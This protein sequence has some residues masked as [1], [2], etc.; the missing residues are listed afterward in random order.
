M[1]HLVFLWLLAM[2]ILANA[3]GVPAVTESVETIPSRGSYTQTFLFLRV[4]KP[5]ATL[6]L[7]S[8]NK[9]YV[10]IF[11]NGSAQFDMFFVY[12]A[13]RLLAQQGFNVLLLDAPSEWGSGGL[14]E[15]QRTPEYIAHNSA[16]LAWARKQT[17]VPV[18]LV[19]QSSGGITAAA[20]ASQLKGKGADGLILVSPWMPTKENW[21]IPNFV[22]SSDF[23]IASWTDLKEAKGPRL[24]IHHLEDNCQFSLPT[25]VL[26]LKAAFGSETPLEVMGLKGGA[27]PSGN[28]CYPAGLN[29]FTG[30]EQDV[31]TA[32][33]NWVKAQTEQANARSN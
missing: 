11:P 21:P 27:T 18:F 32:I 19:G 8:G 15:K 5:L 26:D 29:N 14:W 20:V 7:Y 6:L 12:R 4:E 33:G 1:K 31:S 2:D 30:L 13:R 24:L 17:N 16:V 3:Q 28:P 23:A 10:G 25:Y 22:Y 9:G